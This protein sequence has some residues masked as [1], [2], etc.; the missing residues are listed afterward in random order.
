MAQWGKETEA[1]GQRT[2]P[3]TVQQV[4]S[5]LYTNS[6]DNPLISGGQVTGN[7][8][9]TFNVNAGV[10]LCTTA[11]GSSYV[12][13]KATKTALVTPPAT[14]TQVW[15]V[16]ASQ[17]GAIGVSAAPAAPYVTLGKFSVPAGA[18]SMAGLPN[19]WNTNYALPYGARLPRLAYWRENAGGGQAAANQFVANVP[20][21][22]Q[23]DRTIQV[24]I[25]QELYTQ[26]PGNDLGA[27]SVL[28]D[29]NLDNGNQ[30][31][32]I[33]LP[34]DRR[35][36]IRTYDWITD[37]QAGSHSVS[38][39]RSNIWPGGDFVVYHFGLQDGYDPGGYFV[40]DLGPTQ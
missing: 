13:W 12:A 14:G 20:F 35:R 40:Y 19:L 30:L 31:G 36:T 37:V 27:G 26:P 23:T 39:N 2:T 10:G 9:R 6:G 16:Y 32:K 5:A 34:V 22:V 24:T 17:D 11:A 21:S 18:T 28:W 4:W 38:I 8:D 3:E 33:E 1:G 29:I 15:T 25:W 7:A